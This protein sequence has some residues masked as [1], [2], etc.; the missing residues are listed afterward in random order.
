MPKTLEEHAIELGL[1]ISDDVIKPGDIYLV[2]RSERVELLTCDYI[3][4]NYIV[5][6]E[7][8]HPSGPINAYCFDV[9]KCKK[10]T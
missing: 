7:V 8:D 2:Q 9:W 4:N 3:I 1:K 10:V 5:P 6:R